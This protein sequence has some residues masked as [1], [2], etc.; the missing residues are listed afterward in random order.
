MEY[1]LAIATTEAMD[2]TRVSD[3]FRTAASVVRSYQLRSRGE[4]HGV[5]EGAN[6]A[7]A[8]GRDQ[9][10]IQP[11]PNLLIL[12]RDR[13]SVD[14]RQ[15]LELRFDKALAILVDVDLLVVALEV[16]VY[17]V[18]VTAEEKA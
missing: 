10:S 16:G 14:S 2:P 11:H 6:P 5:A 9:R 7:Q 8:L 13:K 18:A 4:T 17:A 1:L 12:V 3:P 15:R